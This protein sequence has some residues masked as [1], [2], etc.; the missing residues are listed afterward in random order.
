VA[1]WGEHRR[2]VAP[3]AAVVNAGDVD[4]RLWLLG[5]R[6]A[7]VELEEALRFIGALE[8]CGGEAAPMASSQAVVAD[9][10]VAS[11]GGGGGGGG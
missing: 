3:A 11:A 7:A 1:G 6:R 10:V 2:P 9:G 8:N 5:G 4:L